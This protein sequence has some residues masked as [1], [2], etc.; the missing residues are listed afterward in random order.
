MLE[1]CIGEVQVVRF[2]KVYKCLAADVSL[3][4]GMQADAGLSAR[5]LSSHFCVEIASE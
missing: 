2:A 5:L 4:L 3:P 1:R